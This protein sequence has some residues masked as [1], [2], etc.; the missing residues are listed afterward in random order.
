MMSAAYRVAPMLPRYAAST[1]GKR[2]KV[3]QK[4]EMGTLMKTL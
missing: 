3:F 2:V 1:G 4:H